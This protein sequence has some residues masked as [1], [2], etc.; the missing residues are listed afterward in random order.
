M[1]LEND[2]PANNER[3]LYLDYLKFIVFLGIVVAHVNAPNWLLA[4]R[5]FGVPLLVIASAVLAN[6]ARGSTVKEAIK[7][8]KNNR[9]C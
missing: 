1:M 8:N 4:L 7:E 2:F 5:S 3:L 6:R 9:S